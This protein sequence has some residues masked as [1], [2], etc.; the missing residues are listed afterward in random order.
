MNLVQ[1]FITRNPCCQANLNRAD[2]SYSK[3]Q[4]EGAQGLM[5]HS[6]GCAQPSAEVFCKLWDSA[7]Y[8]DACVHAFIDA[9]TGTVWQTLPWNYRGWHCDGSGNNTHIGVEM[10]ESA[11]IRYESGASF[12]VIDRTKAVEDCVRTYNSAVELFA[13]LCIKLTLDP[14]TCICSHK[15]G[16][17]SGIASC[18]GDPEHYWEGLGMNYSMD[19]FRRDVLKKMEESNM[20][21]HEELEELIT[22]MLDREFKA[23]FDAAYAEKMRELADNEAGKWSLEA[24][25]WAIDAGI[26]RGI[27]IGADGKPNYAW[28][29]P[30]TRE[31]YAA[32]EY[33]QAMNGV[34]KI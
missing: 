22:G 6:V 28:E 12:T 2:A 16:A 15:E 14:Q 33:R 29:Q 27:G 31:Q 21:T 20:Q 24:R 11:A 18:H 19:G 1:R 8:T 13:D 23:R 25:E 32:T 9:N 30:L 34:C 5:L 10:C 17:A 26:I 3:F 7:D 4:D